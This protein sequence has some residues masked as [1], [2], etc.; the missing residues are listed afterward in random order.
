MAVSKAVAEW[1]F[2]GSCGEQ[3]TQKRDGEK[4]MKKKEM[5]GNLI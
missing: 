4:S 3:E 5:F 1:R 2:V